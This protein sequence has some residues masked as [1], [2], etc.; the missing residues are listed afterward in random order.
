MCQVA[1]WFC[2]CA[3]INQ[4]PLLMMDFENMNEKL[5]SAIEVLVSQLEDQLREAAETKKMINSLRKR[6]GE[7][8]MFADVEAEQVHSATIRADQFYGK[9]L[10]TAAQQ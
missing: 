10:A 9:P 3:I 8:P 7:E 5:Q 2:V 4:H 6:M 1:K